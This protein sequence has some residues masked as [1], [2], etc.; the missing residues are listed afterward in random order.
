[1]LANLLVALLAHPD[2]MN[3]LRK[4]PSRSCRRP[5][6]STRWCNSAAGIVRF[7]EREATIGGETLAAGP[8]LYHVADRSP[9]RAEEIYP[10]PEPSTSIDDP[11]GC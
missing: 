8:I 5:S 2:A 7:V 4:Q 10:R 6:K 1:M 3:Q 11:W 9:L